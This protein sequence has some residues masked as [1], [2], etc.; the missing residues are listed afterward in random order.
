MT[1]FVILE[2]PLEGNAPKNGEPTAGFNFTTMLKLTGR[3]WP[4]ISQQ[5][6]K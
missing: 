5:R 3:Y 4:R 2:M 1:S 6:T